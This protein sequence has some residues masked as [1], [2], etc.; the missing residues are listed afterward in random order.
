MFKPGS[1]QFNFVIAEAHLKV[2]HL[3]CRRTR[4]VTSPYQ[5][6]AFS[7]HIGKQTQLLRYFY[8]GTNIVNRSKSHH[9]TTFFGYNLT[10]L[11]AKPSSRDCPYYIS[12]LKL[13]ISTDLRQRYHRQYPGEVNS[14]RQ[15]FLWST[16]GTWVEIVLSGV[17]IL[18]TAYLKKGHDRVVFLFEYCTNYYATDHRPL[19]CGQT[20]TLWR[21]HFLHLG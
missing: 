16:T 17:H 20:M 7:A 4:L 15:P 11:R 21:C 9:N 13:D 3:W 5:A 14:S 19:K 2:I 1:I 10:P 6:P 8:K 12:R 18:A